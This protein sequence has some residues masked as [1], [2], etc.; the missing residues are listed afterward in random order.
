MNAELQTENLFIPFM[1]INII[2]SD[3]NIE[4]K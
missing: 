3:M 1:D 4:P 2:A